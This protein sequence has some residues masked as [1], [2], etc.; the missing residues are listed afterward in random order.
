MYYLW[1]S[2]SHLKLVSNMTAKN[3]P[4]FAEFLLRV[5]GGTEDTNSDGDIRLPDD[6]CVPYS[7]S[8]SN[9]DNLI[10]FAFPN[11]NEN[12]FDSTYITSRAIL[13]T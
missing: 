5:G 10:D 1:E 13:S 8:D 11:L 7:G 2:M 6:V 12:M 4:W 9:L 3:D